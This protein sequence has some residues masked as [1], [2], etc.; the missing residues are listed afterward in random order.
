MH[1]EKITK[2]L[3]AAEGPILIKVTIAKAIP[4][5]LPELVDEITGLP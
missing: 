4:R 2:Y 5:D 3:N 1:W